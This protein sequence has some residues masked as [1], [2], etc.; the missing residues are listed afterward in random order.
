MGFAKT[1]RAHTVLAATRKPYVIAKERHSN[2]I[3]RRTDQE[4]GALGQL[5]KAAVGVR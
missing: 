5:V 2:L 1:V 4:A 3:V